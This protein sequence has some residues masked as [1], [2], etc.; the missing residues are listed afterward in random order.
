MDLRER[1]RE[2]PVLS[3]CERHAALQHDPAV[4]RAEGSD[5][6]DQGDDLVPATAEHLGGGECERARRRGQLAL[7][8][9]SHNG[10]G[11]EDVD[12]R[13]RE[14]SDDRRPS[15]SLRSGS[16]TS[17]A[18]TVADSR[19]MNAQSVSGA[20]AEIGAPGSLGGERRQVVAVD[21]EESDHADDREGHELEDR[22]DDLNR[23]G[24]ACAGDVDQRQQPDH[25]DAHD[26][27]EQIVGPQVTPED[28]EVT[29]ERHGDRGVP[30]PGGNPVA[31][32]GLEPDEVAEGTTRVR[33][34]A[35]GSWEGAPETREYEGQQH[36]S[37]AGEDPAD[38]RDG[39]R[40][41]GERRRQQKHPRAD[42]VADHQGR[43]HGESHR[44]FQVLLGHRGAP[45]SRFPGRVLAMAAMLPL[46]ADRRHRI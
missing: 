13:R 43:G 39:T 30:R 1:G 35:S 21:E 2:Q 10:D 5:H 36:G 9:D 42:H 23:A 28:G 32:G 29:D 34:R 41:V 22:G 20:A 6:G 15:G 17:P 26:C 37:H 40:H 38:D 31:P 12:E 14:R 7:G 24:L 19:P 3:S 18:A 25:R 46:P 4:E 16:L 33:V 11:G 8:D 44:A 27:R 45:W